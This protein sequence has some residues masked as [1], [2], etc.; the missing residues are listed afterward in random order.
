MQ[1]FEIK[2]KLF[3]LKDIPADKVQ[4]AATAFIDNGL[5]KD[6]KML[7]LHSVNKF[8]NYVFDSLYPIEKDKLYKACNIY[9]LTIR[10]ISTE[11]AEYFSKILV[12]QYNTV[13]KGL[14]SE[15]RIIPRKHI[16]KIYSLTPITLKTEQGYW[17]G[18][19]SLDD[20]EKRLKENLIK[21]YNNIMNDK[22]DESFPLYTSLQFDNR[23]PIATNYKNIKILGDKVTLH[24]ADDEQSQ[25]LAY[26][27]LG[28][29]VYEMNSRGFG[30][31]NYRWL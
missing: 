21:K 13:I 28:T 24:I 4:T 2:L 23:Q 11:L 26:M 16:Q 18:I 25:L 12:H 17:R 10:T 31:M 8:K 29:G 20:F 30:F 1:V 27:S 9:T 3:L 22:M 5:L 14:T 19:L 7:D 15:I 6:E